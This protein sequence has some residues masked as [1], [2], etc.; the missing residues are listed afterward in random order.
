[1][2]VF[3]KL[4]GISIPG[5]V[6]VNNVHAMPAL[7]LATEILAIPFGAFS[8]STNLPEMSYTSRFEAA[9]SEALPSI[10][11]SENLWWGWGRW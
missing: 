4:S 6:N 11:I 3:G 1:M 10:L 8:L 5:T 9:R 7:K 2:V